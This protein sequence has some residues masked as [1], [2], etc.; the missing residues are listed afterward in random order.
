L[1][2]VCV[3]QRRNPSGK[4]NNLHNSEE[5]GKRGREWD[6]KLMQRKAPL[7]SF[8]EQTMDKATNKQKDHKDRHRNIR[9]VIAIIDSLLCSVLIHTNSN[10]NNNICAASRMKYF[11]EQTLQNKQMRQASRPIL[12]DILFLGAAFHKF[13]EKNVSPASER[14]QDMK[15]FVFISRAKS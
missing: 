11:T 2:E 9:N 15:Y 1:S 14:R 8:G 6:H 10:N 5:L 12:R 3:A 13:R 7:T 4:H